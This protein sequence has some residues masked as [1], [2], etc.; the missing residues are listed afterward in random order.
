M[1][2]AVFG[3]SGVFGRRLAE[4]LRRDGHAVLVLGRRDAPLQAVAA[5]IGATACVLD[6][7]GDLSPLWD[8]QPDVLIDAAG[9]FHAY[10]KDPYALPRA[11]I[12][13]GVHYLD[14]ADDADFCAGIGALDDAARAAGVFAL[15]GASS[16]PGVSSAVAAALLT[17]AD[18]VDTISA[19]ILPGNRADRG[20]AVI[21]SILHQA[22][23]TITQTTGGRPTPIQSWSAPEAFDLARH[24][25]RRGYVIAVPDQRLF[26]VHFAARTV[27]FRAGL[28][29]PVM[30]VGLAAL[31]RVRAWTGLRL[32]NA[33]IRLAAR[34]L[35]PFG[36]DQGGMVVRTM[37]RHGA[38]WRDSRWRLIARAGDGP[39]IPA[40]TARAIVRA[41]SDVPAGARPA[42]AEVSLD[43][44]TAAMADLDVSTDLSVQPFTPLFPSVLGASFADLPPA[45]RRSHD[46]AG[47]RHLTGRAS[48]TRGTTLIA[49]L[50]AAVFGFPPATDDVE[51]TVTKSPSA[52]AE[53]WERRFGRR[54]FRSTLRATS[55]GMSETFWPFTFDLDLHVAADAL[56]FPVRQ[57]RLLG[58]PLP[59]WA[60]PRSDAQ[61]T[62]VDG[63][64]HF[65][66]A[67]YA[68]FTG[69][70]IVHYRGHLHD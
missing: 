39:Y 55:T 47:P 70:L 5:S 45:V 42:L 66:V 11:A 69:D 24:M 25:R 16:V 18:A 13:H 41:A 59:T 9:P 57:G 58:I 28:E 43:Q 62:E 37:A 64:F 30:N 22:G 52:G 63:V 14:L 6:R 1:K 53:L 67:L 56:H 68:P 65:D 54:I 44:I 32:P 61:E 19:A 17:G 36:T 49:R 26:P 40:V 38:A 27:T 50:I 7:D 48:V 35:A 15:S 12:A 23:T 20:P 46:T 3:G 51:V 21:D 8:Y 33:V 2:V 29:L 4:L 31:A 34:L 10:G 60:L